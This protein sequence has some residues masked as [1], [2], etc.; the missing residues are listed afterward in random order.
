MHGAGFCEEG[1]GEDV[2]KDLC[3]NQWM[4]CL[5]ES[6]KHRLDKLRKKCWW[7]KVILSYQD[8]SL[9]TE[10][11]NFLTNKNPVSICKS[12]CQGMNLVL[13]PLDSLAVQLLFNGCFSIPCH[14]LTH[15]TFPQ[16]FIQDMCKYIKG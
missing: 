6:R 4:I 7:K 9:L 16:P 8:F 5:V 11:F 13:F 14:L 12:I 2:Q 3:Q 15:L 1:P 10:R